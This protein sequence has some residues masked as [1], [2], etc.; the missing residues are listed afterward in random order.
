MNATTSTG[1][2]PLA[3][4]QTQAPAARPSVPAYLEQTYWWAYVHP[5]AVRWFEREWLVNLILFGNYGRLRDQ[6]LAAAVA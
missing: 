6:A 3:G 4:L 2:A 5:R 1:V